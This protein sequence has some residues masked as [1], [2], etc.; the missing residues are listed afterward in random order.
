MSSSQFL[1]YTSMVG[2]VHSALGEIP[3][4]SKENIVYIS[5][6]QSPLRIQTPPVCVTFPTD[7]FATLAFPTTRGKFRAF[8]KDVEEAIVTMAIE[9]R[10]K[11]FHQETSEEDVRAT[12]KSYLSDVDDGCTSELR[13]RRPE[14]MTVYDSEGAP[15]ELD[16]LGEGNGGVQHAYA[17]LELCRLTFG[18]SAWGAMWKIQQLRQLPR[19]LITPSSELE[20][21]QEE[22]QEEEQEKEESQGAVSVLDPQDAEF[23]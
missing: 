2:L 11:W 20:K 22:E 23:I 8:I 16:T 5:H 12:H 7:N 10:H 19:C 6:L 14:G 18:R 1:P 17:A 13:V 15:T 9:N 3:P 4:P 21:E